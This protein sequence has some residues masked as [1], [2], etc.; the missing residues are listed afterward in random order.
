MN[1]LGVGLF[2]AGALIALSSVMLGNAM[3]EELRSMPVNTLMQQHGPT[4]LKFLVFA[5]GFPLGIGVSLLGALTGSESSARR[6]LFILCAVLLAASTASLVPALWGRQLSSIFFGNGGYLIMLLMLASIWY[7]GR[8]R[9]GVPQAQR[10]AVD[11]QGIG[12]LCFAVAVWN[13]CGAATMPSFVLEP[14]KMLAMK[15]QAFATGQMK[16]IM[17]LFILGWIFT[18]LGLRLAGMRK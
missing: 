13:I 16:A 11:L 18:L 15:S 7:W 14:D 10:F 1:R 8:Y 9:A 6:Y 4:S 2:T 3:Q 12:Y 5:F 17:V